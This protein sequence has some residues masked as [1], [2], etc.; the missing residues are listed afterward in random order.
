MIYL[1]FIDFI[2]WFSQTNFLL[3]I[4]FSAIGFA[5]IFISQK[6]GQVFSNGDEHCQRNLNIASKTIGAA[7]VCVALLVMIFL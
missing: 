4:I 2:L 1:N 7:L 6:L 3:G 5:F